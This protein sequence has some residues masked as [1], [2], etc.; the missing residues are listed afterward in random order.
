MKTTHSSIQWKRGRAR[1]RRP[2]GPP[3]PRRSWPPPR[4]T[5]LS[6]AG[7]R[8]PKIHCP[9]RRPHHTPCR[10]ALQLPPVAPHCLSFTTW[11][12]V[13]CTRLSGARKQARPESAR[14]KSLA[15]PRHDEA[16]AG[17]GRRG[18]GPLRGRAGAACCMELHGGA[19]VR[20]GR[21]ARTATRARG[22]YSPLAKHTRSLHTLSRRPPHAPFTV[23]LPLLPG[24][25]TRR[26]TWAPLRA[27]HSWRRCCRLRGRCTSSWP[28]AAAT[29]A[30]CCP[31]PPAQRPWVT[32]CTP[33]RRATWR[34]RR[35]SL[36]TTSTRRWRPAAAASR[37]WAARAPPPSAGSG[38]PSR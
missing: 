37:L 34:R 30:A 17:G 16:R 35:P 23:A 14:R 3:S 6:H 26:P 15:H 21:L 36:W 2:A 25:A 7:S 32:R 31:R 19:E 38:T 5:R 11:S 10:H 13:L 22:G 8:W 12:R 4:G 29:W 27:R 20:G 24:A 28:P 18:G 9:R 1:A 33:P